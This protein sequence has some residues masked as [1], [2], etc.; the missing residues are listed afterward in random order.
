MSDET[1]YESERRLDVIIPCA[2]KD[3][4]TLA[5]CIEGV[6]RHVPDV[7]RIFVVSSR[8]LSLDA[9]WLPEH[10]YPFSL[11]DVRR[12]VPDAG[13]RAGW[14][15]Q[16][17]L[18]LYA[19]FVLPDATHRLLVV[20]AD[21][22]FQRRCPMLDDDGQPLYATGTEMHAPYFA[23]MDRLLP[24]LGRVTD[25]SGIVHHMVLDRGV[26]TA[27]FGEVEARHQR[28]FWQAFL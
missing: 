26:L 4:A 2:D 10:G 24:G 17:L 6:R 28:P 27:L 8:R 18:K 25:A 3:Q 22:V 21:T 16:Q 14:Y 12:L 1:R 20:D 11:A 13:E 7:R 15:L 9:E 5:E 23:H 19:A